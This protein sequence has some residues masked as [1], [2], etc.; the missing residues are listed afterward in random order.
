M[1]KKYTISYLIPIS[2]NL[3]LRRFWLHPIFLEYLNSCINRESCEIQ[4][5]YPQL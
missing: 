5:L 2:F 4:E 1:T 3:Y